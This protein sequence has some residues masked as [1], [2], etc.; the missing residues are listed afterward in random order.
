MDRIYVN[1]SQDEELFKEFAKKN[2]FIYKR[3][4][5]FSKHGFLLNGEDTNI[6]ILNVTLE[7]NSFEYYPYIDTLANYTPHNSNLNNYGG[8]YTLNETDGTNGEEEGCETC[9]GEE[10]VECPEC[11]GGGEIE[12]PY[13]E[14]NGEVDCSEC[15]GMGKEESLSCD[16][17]GLDDE[18]NECYRDW[19]TDRK[20]TRL[21]T[22]HLKLSRMPS[23]A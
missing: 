6:E 21:N 22:S 9:D 13:C 19:E 4:Q 23:S 5:G 1:N 20:S 16:G 8:E 10:S 12:C 15:G 18:D 14:G 7:Y 11:Y 17:T 3:N 2:G